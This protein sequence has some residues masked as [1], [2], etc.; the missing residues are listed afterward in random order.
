MNKNIRKIDMV[1]NEDYMKIRESLSGLKEILDICFFERNIYKQM[2][3]DNLRALNENVIELLKHTY[4]PRE[5]RIKM[6]EL[7]YE[8]LEAPNSFLNP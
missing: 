6:R 8:G 2:G 1:F 3:M 7:E 5:V 4:S